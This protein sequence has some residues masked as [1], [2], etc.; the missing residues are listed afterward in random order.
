MSPGKTELAEFYTQSS[1]LAILPAVTHWCPE[2]FLWVAIE[3]PDVFA[4]QARIRP[5][6]QARMKNLNV[7]NIETA[8]WIARLGSF[9]AA[10]EKLHT[11]QPAVSA[12]M[13]ELETALG[14]KLFIRQGR[15]VEL[16]VQGRDFIRTAEPLMLQLEHLSQ[17]ARSAESVSGV[18]R[19]GTGNIC[20]TWLPAMMISL[21][22]EMP[23][24]TYEVE[25]DRAGKLLGR[26]EA[27]KLDLVMVSG[28]VDSH[29]FDALSL[30]Y[31]RMLWLCAP[32]LLDR[33]NTQEMATL[34]NTT[35]LWCV[36]R[37]SFFWSDAL[38]ALSARGASLENVN[39]ISNMSAAMQMALDGAGIGLISE[40]MA[41][42]AVAAGRLV[43]VPGLEPSEPVA[44]SVV[45]AKDDSQALVGRIMAAAVRASSFV[46]APHW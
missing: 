37:E 42:D 31:D 40:A 21:K 7:L 8:C 26:L 20:M 43:S 46:K 1:T 24:V 30:G 33:L 27:R 28:P 36:Q 25:I 11:S 9:T 19:I 32:G 2:L 18:V 5:N 22:A 12:R 15:G 10:A 3:E 45:C 6:H 17:S 4:A 23:R 35:Q 14:I 38:Q 16:T 29:K 13:R 44:L 39:A 34:L 41:G